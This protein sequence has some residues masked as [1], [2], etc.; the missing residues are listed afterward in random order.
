MIEVQD[1]KTEREM[2]CKRIAR[3]S[4]AKDDLWILRSAGWEDGQ[5]VI[6]GFPRSR[7]DLDAWFKV[8]VE[9]WRG[10]RFSNVKSAR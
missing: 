7:E 4:I 5:Y 10:I 8:R 3:K 2:A 6:S 1:R 9:A